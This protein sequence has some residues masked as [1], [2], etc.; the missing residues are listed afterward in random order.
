MEME[1]EVVP[2]FAPQKALWMQWPTTAIKDGVRESDFIPA[3]IEI[4]RACCDQG[5]IH[6][7]V[8]GKQA[9]KDAKNAIIDAGIQID[10]IFFH[11]MP[12]DSCWSRDNG[13]IF[14][15]KNGIEHILDFGFNS[16]GYEPW[17]PFE[18]D[19]E[20]PQ[21]IAKLLDIGITKVQYIEQT[22]EVRDFIYEGGTLEL[23]GEGTIVA[24][25][26]ICKHRNPR[27]DRKQAAEILRNVT[28]SHTVIWIDSIFRNTT[29]AKADNHTD[30]YMKFYEMNRVCVLDSKPDE[31]GEEAASKLENEGWDIYHLPPD[32]RWTLV[33]CLIFNRKVVAGYVDYPMTDLEREIME[34]LFP[35]KK[36]VEIEIGPMVK[37]GGGI[38]CVTQQQPK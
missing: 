37:G 17:G 11:I 7:L 29:P 21:L 27:L 19:D 30:G 24:S 5:E 22:N 25:W 34:D 15:R 20:I 3:F 31:P 9:E 1:Y 4:E 14:V 12:Y 13:P 8:L 28:G 10:N 33:N 32:F 6:N 35:D 38:H 26:A 18:R 16:W 36:I 23:S 2:E